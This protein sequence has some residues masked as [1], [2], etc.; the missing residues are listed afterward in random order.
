MCWCEEKETTLTNARYLLVLARQR[1]IDIPQTSNLFSPP[2][3]PLPEPLN[4]QTK[5][6]MTF[7]IKMWKSVIDM[8]LNV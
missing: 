2:P 4:I 7:K 8:R 6:Q 1:C 3:E 5:N